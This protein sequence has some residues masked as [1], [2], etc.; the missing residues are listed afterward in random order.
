[1]SFKIKPKDVLINVPVVL[2]FTDYREIP[3]FANDFN[4]LL[5]G[6]VKLKSEE[7][8]ILNGKYM[9]IFY[10]ERNS[11]YTS[12]RNSFMNMINEAEC[13]P[14]PEVDV[15]CECGH[16][17]D[18]HDEELDWECNKCEFPEENN[19]TDYGKGFCS[20]FKEKL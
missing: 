1:M 7:L 11:E 17:I 10:L 13:P 19:M 18:D 3:I 2:E 20:C 12:L 16:D 14:V 4:K 8:G 6:K 9:G 5:H 15:L